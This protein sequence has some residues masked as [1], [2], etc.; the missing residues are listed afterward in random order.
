MA[1]L[2]LPSA[3]PWWEGEREAGGRHKLLVRGG[4]TGWRPR[5]SRVLTQGDAY[6]GTVDAGDGT[7]CRGGLGRYSTYK[8][9]GAEP[10]AMT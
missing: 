2:Y 4:A 10:A 5:S 3:A 6:H 1:L 8:L 7:V 9:D